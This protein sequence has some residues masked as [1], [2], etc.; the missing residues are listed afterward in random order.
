MNIGAIR[1]LEGVS[2]APPASGLEAGGI[3][4]EGLLRGEMGG[5]TLQ[6]SRAPREEPG[7][8]EDAGTG[9][10]EAG[11]SQRSSAAGAAS[12][13]TVATG[14]PEESGRSEAIGP[15]EIA[16][17][18]EAGPERAVGDVLAVLVPEP[19]STDSAAS[20]LAQ[21]SPGGDT[22]TGAMA[23]SDPDVA[24]EVAAA[25]VAG[26]PASGSVAGAAPLSSANSSDER[27]AAIASTGV[28]RGVAR[29]T[30]DAGAAAPSDRAEE[31]SRGDAQSVPARGVGD[32]AIAARSGPS[33]AANPATEGAAAPIA[34][35]LRDARGEANDAGVEAQTPDRTNARTEALDG[36]VAG[37]TAATAASE[38][39]LAASLGSSRLEGTATAAEARSSGLESGAEVLQASDRR[40]A[41]EREADDRLPPGD[42]SQERTPRVA[43]KESSVG[44][45][46]RSGF[47]SPIAGAQAASATAS[48]ETSNGAATAVA[49]I[50]AASVG[51]PIPASV[52]APASAVPAPPPAADA[53]AIQTEW[54]ATRGG[55][56][57]RLVLHP[58]ELGEIAIRV[59]LRDGAVDIVMIAHEAAAKAIADEQ[60]DRL[61]QAFSA[62]DLRMGSFEV[63]QVETRAGLES[64]PESQLGNPD[65]RDGGRSGHD[66]G[67]ADA[68]R[69]DRVAAGPPSP[70]GRPADWPPGV[71]A[72]PAERRVD[73]RI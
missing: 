1:S 24:V 27:A 71:R 5:S 36:R 42:R 11:A 44:L 69:T 63:R 31:G 3:G 22:I 58:P 60:S 19:P 35:G 55:G 6:D 12:L 53:L 59:S 45:A 40:G 47:E 20:D 64:G 43:E 7:N 26:A 34:S 52:E 14:E 39:R 68:G 13:E 25:A 28:G 62:R 73:L 9:R 41:Q 54:L 4:F 48:V 23:G 18:A 56:S 21:P 61:A 67:G 33:I 50:P 57:A 66:P 29:P 32:E 65:A 17:A 8:P 15:E 72:T 38:S 70:G 46:A 30:P 16:M 51:A 10:F 49:G 37:R 2:S